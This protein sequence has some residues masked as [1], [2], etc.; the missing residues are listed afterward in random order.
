MSNQSLT[1]RRISS[2]EHSRFLNTLPGVS[3]LQRPEWAQ[4]KG[5]WR[6]ESLGWFDGQTQVGA[7]L[8]LHRAAPIIGRTLAYVPD[9]PVIDFAAY[10][11][12]QVLSQLTTHLK[13]N[14]AF[15]LRVGPAADRTVWSA[16]DV[17]KAMGAG[18]LKELWELEPARRFPEGEQLDAA[19]AQAGFSRLDAGLDFAA[20][21]PEY[22]ARVPLVTP[23]G[24]RLDIDQVLALFSQSARRETRQSLKADLQI[25]V[26]TTADMARF[27][28]LYA[29]TADRQEFTGRPLSYFENLHSSL[30]AAV[31]GS[32]VL[33]FASHEGQDLATAVRIRSG[34]LSW[35]LYGASGNEHRKLNAPKALQ[36]RM[37]ADAINEGCIYLD[38]GGVT[39][40]LQRGEAHGG[41]SYFKTSMGCD[42]V[43]TLGEWEIPL[44]KPLAWGFQKYMD[45]R[46]RR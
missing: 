29:T 14:G 18:E 42:V 10:P 19:L 12:A 46:A 15:A 24:A 25:E 37:L 44:S 22:V 9:G 27:H 39:P 5:E 23:E 26:G 8:V 21:Q 6:G 30:N 3:I 13:K 31:P 4:V 34:N 40:T 45:F 1:L 38:Q 32:C 7:A 28:A 41:L 33:Y 43:R 35:Y 17:R 16:I 11:A 2:D 36:H 20:G